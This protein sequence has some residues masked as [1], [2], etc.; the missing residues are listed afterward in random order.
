MRKQQSCEIVNISYMSRKFIESGGA[1]YHAAKFAMEGISC[2]LIIMKWL[3]L[4]QEPSNW[5]TEK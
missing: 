5:R 1:W 2:S 3:L 4:N